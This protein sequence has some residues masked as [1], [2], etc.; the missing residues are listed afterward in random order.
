MREALSGVSRWTARILIPALLRAHHRRVLWLSS[1]ARAARCYS[2]TLLS[3]VRAVLSVTRAQLPSRSDAPLADLLS[4]GRSSLM[5]RH[6]V[7]RRRLTISQPRKR[8]SAVQQ[9][10]LRGKE[11]KRAHSRNLYSSMLLQFSY[12]INLLLCL[13]YKLYCAPGIYV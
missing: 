1:R 12:F 6:R 5:L 9:D 4:E 7:C 10:I 3:G 8:M 11:K 2:S 13:I